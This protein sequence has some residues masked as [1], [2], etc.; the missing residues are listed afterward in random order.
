ML[1]ATPS[2][3]ATTMVWAATHDTRAANRTGT[4]SAA[5]EPVGKAPDNVSAEA[6]ASTTMRSPFQRILGSPLNLQTSDAGPRFVL[7]GEARSRA[8][9]AAV[10]SAR[11]RQSPATGRRRVSSQWWEDH[12]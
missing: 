9:G 4:P 7:V 6:T 2:S 12:P 1:T 10:F 11:I 3:V 8:A 5:S